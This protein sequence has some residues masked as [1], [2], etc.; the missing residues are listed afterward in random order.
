LPKPLRQLSDAILTAIVVV[1]VT[2]GIWFVDGF[3]VPPGVDPVVV[4][5]PA[6]SVV[7]QPTGLG[8][9]QRNP[10]QTFIEAIQTQFNDITSQYADDIIQTL[11]VDLDRDRLIVQ[12]NPAWYTIGDDGQNRL[13]DK[14]WLQAQTNHFTKLEIRDD[15]GNPVARSPVVGQHAI[16]LQRQLSRE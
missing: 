12:L 3:F 2:V 5:Q 9:P 6:T 14:M 16:V 13:T 1:F 10:E 4:S 11:Q 7:A 15:R 8:L